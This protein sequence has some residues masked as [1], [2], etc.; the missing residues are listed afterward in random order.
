M[1]CFEANP[2]KGRL[3]SYGSVAGAEIR[4]TSWVEVDQAF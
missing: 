4:L 2:A 1:G 3:Q